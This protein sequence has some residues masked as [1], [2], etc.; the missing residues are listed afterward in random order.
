[1]RTYVVAAG[2]FVLAVGAALVD[3]IFRVAGGRV[4]TG[5]VGRWVAVVTVVDD[6]C[7]DRGAIGCCSGLRRMTL[8]STKTMP[9]RE[10]NPAGRG[11]ALTVE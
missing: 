10:I 6:G 3:C 5:G 8:V 2:T 11:A 1:M 4:K 7:R 9:N